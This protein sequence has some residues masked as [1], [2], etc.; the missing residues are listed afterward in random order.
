[1]RLSAFDTF[2]LFMAL[3]NHFTTKSYDF[4]KYKGKVRFTQET[5]LSNK[6]K[7]LY[8]K[9][10]RVCD[11]SDLTD[12]LIA[13]FIADK[14]WVRDFLDEEAKDRF[15]DYRKRKQS[16][17]YM[18]GNELDKLFFIQAPELAFRPTGNY[19]LPIRMYMQGDMS[20]ETLALLSKY[21][22]LTESYDA[23]YG[24]DDIVWG[25]ISMLLKKFTPFLTCDDKKMKSILKDKINENI[26][27][28]E[29][30]TSRAP[31]TGSEEVQKGHESCR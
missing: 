16:L 4:V 24:E 2:R 18:F 14:K 13:T 9:L 5:F 27:R 20:L 1:M 28:E 29:Q 15:T 10:S 25:K 22:G 21:L 3:K 19:A 17:G 6:D 23:K 8:Q 7:L 30:E 31:Q 11:E 12:Y 26:S